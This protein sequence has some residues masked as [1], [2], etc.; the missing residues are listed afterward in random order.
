MAK[1]KIYETGLTNSK[2]RLYAGKLLEN[3]IKVTMIVM[4]EHLKP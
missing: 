3:L 1:F 2:A 4:Y